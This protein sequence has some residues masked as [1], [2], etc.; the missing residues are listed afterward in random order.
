VLA[1]GYAVVVTQVEA[2]SGISRSVGRHAPPGQSAGGGPYYILFAAA[3]QRARATVVED[4][5]DDDMIEITDRDPLDK[6]VSIDARRWIMSKVAPAG[7]G[8]KVILGGIMAQSLSPADTMLDPLLLTGRGITVGAISVGDYP[9]ELV[10]DAQ[11]ALRL[12]NSITPPS[13]VIRPP[14]K[15][16]LTF[17][18]ATAGRSK[19]RGISSFIRVCRSS[20][21]VLLW[22]RGCRLFTLWA[23]PAGRQNRRDYRTGGGFMKSVPGGSV[24]FFKDS[25]QP[26]NAGEASRG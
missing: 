25:R 9:G 4:W 10:G 26:M 24:R 22:P 14:S 12:A 11:P 20:I 2:A 8:D 1:A 21:A 7:C 15:A 3:Y 19:G 17:L 13:E 23:I 5:L 16:A 18:R 6:R